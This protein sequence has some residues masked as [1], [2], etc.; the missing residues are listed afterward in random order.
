[1]VLGIVLGGGLPQPAAAQDIWKPKTKTTP[2]PTRTPPPGRR[3]PR[4][5]RRESPPPATT[6]LTVQ[7]QFHKFTEEDGVR[8][9][10]SSGDTFSPQDMLQFSI[11]V[12]QNGFLYVILQ[13]TPDGDGQLLF[14]S[15]YHNGGNSF[16]KEDQE[17]LLPSDCDG[18]NVPC[19]FKLSP[20]TRE[21][22]LTIIFSRKRVDSLPA[23]VARNEPPAVVPAQVLSRL[24]A[25]SAQQLRR[26]DGIR[27]AGV[28]DDRNTFW[29]TNDNEKNNEEIIYTMTLKGGGNV[30][31]AAGA[32]VKD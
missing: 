25:A 12:N 17:F 32:A 10:V 20:S 31:A 2:T 13:R 16:V 29:V 18:F 4:P 26:T 21:E 9:L 23:Q 5:S 1:M 28:Q 22:K 14:P 7:G 6:L 8:K 11:K 3:R 19:W 30:K 24:V 15:K 27:V